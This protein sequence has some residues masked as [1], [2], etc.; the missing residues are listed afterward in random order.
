MIYIRLPHADL[1]Q[2][3]QLGKKKRSQRLIKYNVE[4]LF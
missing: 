4:A 3:K 2:R 1:A